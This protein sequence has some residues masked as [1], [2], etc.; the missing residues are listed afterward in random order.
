MQ[1]DVETKLD[2]MLK[3]SIIEPSNSA[4][5]SLIVVVRKPDGSN[6]VCVVFSKVEQ[7]YYF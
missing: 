6:R 4:Y 5:A 1:A 3:V 2:T 7:N